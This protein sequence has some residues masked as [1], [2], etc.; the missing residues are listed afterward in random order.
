MN[1]PPGVYIAHAYTHGVATPIIEY[2]SVHKELTLNTIRKFCYAATVQ[3]QFIDYYK[4]SIKQ[5]SSTD[6]GDCSTCCAKCHLKNHP[7]DTLSDR[8]V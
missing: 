7:K 5:Y 1:T 8:I 2:N 6:P 4:S 3:K